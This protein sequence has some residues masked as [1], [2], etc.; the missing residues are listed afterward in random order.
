MQHRKFTTCVLAGVVIALSATT[1][2]A[3][4]T[5]LKSGYF[6]SNNKSIFR[7]AYD[8]FTS[9]VNDR[10]KGEISIAKTVGTEAMPSR[11][12][13]NA[14]KSGLLDV[15]GIPPAY[16]ANLVKLATSFVGSTKNAAEMRANGAWKIY[17]EEFAKKSNTY[18]LAQHG[19]T[20]EFNIYTNKPISSIDD[21]KG[22]K[23][24][25]SNTYKA[26]FDALGTRALQMPR[27]EIF[28]AMERGVV[29]GFANLK[30]EVLSQGW[31]EVAKYRVD[32]G[33]YHPIIIVA[34]NLDKWKGMNAKQQGVLEEAGLYLEGQLSADM[35]RADDAAGVTMVGKGMKVSALPAAD[36]EKFLKLAYESQWD[37]A[38]KRDPET[39]K[40]LR[41]LLYGK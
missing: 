11:Q 12:M 33:F 14:V 21:F 30:S 28:T 2:N 40:K 22:L 25:T 6:I 24:R 38:E 36:A 19:G 18:L 32:P 1:A 34:V 16:M 3:A 31:A 8:G 7:I 5:V 20:A 13:G 27:R 4:E 23:L 17:Q 39:G 15:A 41:S 10:G 37:L 26:F 29:D 35:G 9:R